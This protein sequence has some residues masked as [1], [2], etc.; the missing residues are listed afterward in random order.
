MMVAG[1][2]A[3]FRH[4]R[5]RSRALQANLH[6]VRHCAEFRTMQSR[7]RSPCIFACRDHQRR[8]KKRGLIGNF[9]NAGAKVDIPYGIYELPH[10]RGAV[11]V[12]SS[13]DTPAISTSGTFVF[14]RPVPEI[15]TVL[16]G[17]AECRDRVPGSCCARQDLIDLPRAPPVA[18]P[19]ENAELRRYDNHRDGSTLFVSGRDREQGPPQ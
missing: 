12:G 16:P 5:V 13:H 18:I 2:R 15:T 3:L 10:N 1:F 19:A 8:S 9:K 11:C 14:P 6:R 17:A 7:L 4:H